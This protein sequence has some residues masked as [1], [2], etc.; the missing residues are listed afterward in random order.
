MALAVTYI[1]ICLPF[2]FYV[3]A[4]NLF[5]H[6]HPCLYLCFQGCL[7]DSVGGGVFQHFLLIS[8]KIQMRLAN[9]INLRELRFLLN[10]L[11]SPALL[12]NFAKILKSKMHCKAYENKPNGSFWVAVLG[13]TCCPKLVIKS[14]IKIMTFLTLFSPIL[15]AWLHGSRS[16]FS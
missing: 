6:F 8:F 15:F 2:T 1:S 14:S 3:F 9:F 7:G 5:D 4:Y 11:L 13:E 10:T 16:L 12:P